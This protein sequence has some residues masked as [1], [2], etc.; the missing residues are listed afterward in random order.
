[1]C[2]YYT[3]FTHEVST[4]I[5]KLKSK[6]A[7][8]STRKE[9]PSIIFHMLCTQ[10]VVP[11][12]D[13]TNINFP[14]IIINIYWYCRNCHFS[15]RCLDSVNVSTIVYCLTPNCMTKMGQTVNS[16]TDIDRIRQVRTYMDISCLG[17]VLCTSNLFQV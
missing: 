4:C 12:C 10:R 15:T 9:I 11:T 13:R 17:Q 1:M 8:V 16:C 7:S 14:H 3:L 6:M 2:S 5:V